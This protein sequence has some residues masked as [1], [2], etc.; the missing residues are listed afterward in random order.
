MRKQ[1][2]KLSNPPRVRQMVMGAQIQSQL[3]LTPKPV[4]LY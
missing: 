1:V 3:C 2:K 4:A